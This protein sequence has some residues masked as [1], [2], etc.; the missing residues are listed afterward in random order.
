MAKPAPQNKPNGKLATLK[1]K[2]FTDVNRDQRIADALALVDLPALDF[3]LD[4]QT[5]KWAAENMEI[6][7]I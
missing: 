4:R 7:D 3:S 2:H 5:W 6:E 1:A